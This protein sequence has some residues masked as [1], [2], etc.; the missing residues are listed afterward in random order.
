MLK[1]KL[2][3][4]AVSLSLVTLTGCSQEPWIPI[5]GWQGRLRPACEADHIEAG[6]LARAG[7][8]NAQMQY[9][10]AFF[11]NCG[12]EL[13]ADTGGKYKQLLRDISVQY[14]YSQLSGVEDME[15]TSSGGLTSRFQVAIKA[16]PAPLV[17]V[18]CGLQ[19]DKND[20]T[21]RHMV[22]TLYDEGPFHVLLLPSMT[23]ESYMEEN[24]LVTMG[25]YDEGRRVLEIARYVMS[26]QFKYHNR[27]TRVHVLGTSHGGQ[28]ALYAALYN[29]Y[30]ARANG[31]PYIDTI[32]SG[33][34]VVDLKQAVT[35][36]YT[37]RILGSRF[38]GACWNQILKLA[39]V[40]PVVGEILNRLNGRTPDGKAMP[41]ILAEAAVQHYKEREEHGGWDLPPFQ[42]VRFDEPDD[43]W[44]WNRFQSF[45]NLMQRPV[46]VFA[47]ENDTIVKYPHNTGVLV[48]FL[49]HYPNSNYQILTLEKGNH[50]NVKEAYGWRVGSAFVR[51]LLIAHSPDL[52]ASRKKH[53]ALLRF[54]DFPSDAH[55]D[56][57][58]WRGA[59]RWRAYANSKRLE[60]EMYLVTKCLNLNPDSFGR[61]WSKHVVGVDAMATFG[62]TADRLPKSDL[63]AQGLTRWLNA[64]A[65]VWGQNRGVLGSAEDPQQ[66]EWTTY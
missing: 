45:A 57:K 48:D 34:P 56:S 35:K 44:R 1:A 14:D 51:A 19:C 42:N 46:F 2:F 65:W 13:S 66:V 61:C 20:S 21:F 49:K 30:S 12:K 9:L 64:Q 60:L 5:G 24:H 50:C 18:Q 62:W 16:G 55:V 11:A 8:S 25:G 47:S 28:S 33:C 41:E 3:V 29:G 17:I 39:N 43:V 6:V 38:V 26:P 59:I 63:E 31:L 22:M 7:D 27:V 32:V 37:H 4:A 54:I 15:F 53:A 52:M 58:H 10:Q 40:V 36:I 23:S